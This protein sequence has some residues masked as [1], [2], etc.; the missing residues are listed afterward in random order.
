MLPPKRWRRTS[1]TRMKSRIAPAHEVV[2]PLN[3]GGPDYTACA[4]AL[5]VSKLKTS[6]AVMLRGLLADN[7]EGGERE[8]FDE[9]C[10]LDGRSRVSRPVARVSILPIRLAH[11]HTSSMPSPMADTYAGSDT[12]GNVEIESFAMRLQ[13]RCHAWREMASPPQNGH[14]GLG[15][16]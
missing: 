8:A 14:A 2:P 3:N 1:R 10:A 11:S 13:R 12:P 4:K 5:I 15:L 6:A 9:R 7:G 16:L